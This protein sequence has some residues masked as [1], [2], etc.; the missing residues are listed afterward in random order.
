MTREIMIVA[1]EAS[2]DLHG[3]RLVRSI[4]KLAPETVFYGMGGPELKNEGVELLYDAAKISVVGFFEVVSHLA[5]ILK[6]QKVLRKRLSGSR[7]DLLI[8]IDLPDFNLLLARKAEKLGIP[9]FYY[10]SPQVWAWRSDRVKND[11]PAG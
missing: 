6:A 2:G 3:S 1:G 11:G 10:I 5:D 4:K 9:V 8:L 7:P